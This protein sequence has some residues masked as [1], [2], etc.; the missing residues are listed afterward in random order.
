MDAIPIIHYSN[1]KR[2]AL[3][4]DVSLKNK[5]VHAVPVT[6]TVMHTSSGVQP[7]DGVTDILLSSPKAP[8]ALM[9][10]R[11]SLEQ[12][13]GINNGVLPDKIY[14]SRDCFFTQLV[15]LLAMKHVTSE[16]PFELECEAEGCT[17][18]IA[19]QETPGLMSFEVKSPV[20]IGYIA[21][22]AVTAAQHIELL[23]SCRRVK[24]FKFSIRT[25]DCVKEI[26]VKNGQ[27]EIFREIAHY[28]NRCIVFYTLGPNCAINSMTIM[29]YNG[30]YMM[31]LH[32]NGNVSMVKIAY[33]KINFSANMFV[34]AVDA[35]A[36]AIAR[37]G[38]IAQCFAYRG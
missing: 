2:L 11:S 9:T 3:A 14:S 8:L 37:T 18:K 1:A 32:N 29:S 31:R 15:T 33:T 27:A 35:H 4:V 28:L 17:L 7:A 25:A 5:G 19:S 21:G 30:C 34:C 12:A 6:G 22:T 16:N 23:A 20:G 26:C 24:S 13:G 36:D 38:G 10:T